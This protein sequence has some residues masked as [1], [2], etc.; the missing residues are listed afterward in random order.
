MDLVDKKIIIEIAANCRVSYEALSRKTGLSAN[1]VK[2]R[3]IAL[4]DSGTITRFSV[5]LEAAMIN[6]EYFSAL[7]I[8]DGTEDIDKFVKIMGESPMIGHISIL[9]SAVGGAYF[10]WGQYI[11]SSML[12]ELRTFLRSFSEVQDVEIH[13]IIHRTGKKVVLTNLHLRILSILRKKPRALI[14]EV[15]TIS[16]L[17]PKTVRRGIRELTEGEG[18]VFSARPDM[19]AGKLVNFI[20]RFEWKEDETS[21]DEVLIWLQD[22]YPAQLWDPGPSV[23]EPIFFAEFVVNDLHEAEAIA[24][25]IRSRSFVKST[26]TLVSYSNQKFQY[27]AETMLDEMIREAGY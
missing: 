24:K 26:T 1:A 6:A 25:H 14:N 7:V 5:S 22:E 21:L 10:V 19:A 23:A 17:A 27:L 12:L 18:I 13:T 20:V 9:A 11:G 4:L 2:N 3:V 15:A 8:T 16:D